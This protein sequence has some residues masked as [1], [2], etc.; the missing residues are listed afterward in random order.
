ML[1]TGRQ[2]LIIW[3]STTR[4]TVAAPSWSSKRK[5]DLFVDGCEWSDNV[6][7]SSIIWLLL[8]SLLLFVKQSENNIGNISSGALAAE[9]PNAE[10]SW[11]NTLRPP[12]PLFHPTL[13]I[14]LRIMANALNL[15]VISRVA[16]RC[17]MRSASI[18]SRGCPLTSLDASVSSRR[19]RCSQRVAGDGRLTL[20]ATYSA[21]L[22]I[23]AYF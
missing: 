5:R 11:E 15:S 6:D 1:V 19:H 4:I 8:R 21:A 16:R 2:S 23:Y 9:T 22:Y 14:I 3:L 13:V 12:L 7:C 20:Q 10:E 17:G 18:H